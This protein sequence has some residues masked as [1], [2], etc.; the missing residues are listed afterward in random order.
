LD[1]VVVVAGLHD[2]HQLHDVWALESLH[3]FD[4]ADQ[5]LSQVI[6]PNRFR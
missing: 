5:S 2:V 3:H 4:L 1:D 6:I